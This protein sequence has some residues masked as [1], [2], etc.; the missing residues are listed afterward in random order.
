[1]MIKARLGDKVKVHY[2][3]RFED[4][5]VFD[6]SENSNPLEFVIGGGNLIEGFENAVVGMS[7]G[8]VKTEKIP[9]EDAYGSYNENLIVVVK[10]ENV[11]MDIEP[12][13]GQELEVRSPEGDIIPV[14]VTEVNG[15]IIKLDA[16]HPLAG[17]DLLFDIKLVEIK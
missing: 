11:P 7:P 12:E 14:V 16:N 6:S 2:T 5:E 10:R 1:M 13:P 15:D 17:K 8:E 3:G 9:A 4:G